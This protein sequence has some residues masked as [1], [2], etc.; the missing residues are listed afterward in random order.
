MEVSN[1]L[2][3]ILRSPPPLNLRR[4]FIPRSS[5]MSLSSTHRV[6]LADSLQHDTL[7]TLEWPSL[8]NQLSAFTST[9]MGLHAA[10]NARIPLGR[11]P[12]ESRKL[13]AQTTAAIA[14]QRALDFS[15][16]EDVTEIVDSSVAGE[17]VSIRELCAVKR[18]L[19]SAREVF[20]QLKEISSDS[21][22]NGRCVFVYI[23]FELHFLFVQFVV[24]FHLNE[25]ILCI[26]YV[27]L[28]HDAFT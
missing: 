12:D 25:V 19:R 23:P 28:F 26:S 21:N 2:I 14:L 3:T 18:T 20:E 15:G 17:M 16:I 11:T 7:K 8:C 27:W 4:P 6:K 10:Q 13:L 9:S 24:I 5:S 22:S 1:N